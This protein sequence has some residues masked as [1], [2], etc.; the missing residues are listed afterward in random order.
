[1]S[2]ILSIG[3]ACVRLYSWSRAILPHTSVI[4]ELLTQVCSDWGV[5][6]GRVLSGY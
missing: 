6:I 4:V 1:M 3:L 2:R 5:V